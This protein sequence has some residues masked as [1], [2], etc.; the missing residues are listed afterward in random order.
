MEAILLKNA[1]LIFSYRNELKYLLFT[2]VVI[3]ALP[4]IA[5]IVLTQSGISLVSDALAHYNPQTK[6]IELFYPD[7]T[8]YNTI[9]A[10]TVWPVKGVVTLEFGD[11]DLPYQVFHSG[12]DIANPDGK[13]GDDVVAIMPGK[14]I[15][16]GEISW[17]FG[18]HV[19]IDHGN[20]ITSIYGHLSEI[21]VT[22]GQ[23]V[24]IGEIIGKEGET[25]WATGPHVHLQ[26]DVWGIPVNPRT[27]LGEEDPPGKIKLLSIITYQLTLSQQTQNK[28][29]DL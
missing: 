27:F 13:I 5:V 12:I 26:I 25:G 29:L 15:Y 24:A 8:K 20:N 4:I 14:V 7:G 1:F 23:E 22:E 11:S 19:I 18:K 17:G 2:F 3:L 21:D 9:Q 28:F 10:T 6:S 16:A